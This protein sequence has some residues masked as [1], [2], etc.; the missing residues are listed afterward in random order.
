MN[1]RRRSTQYKRQFRVVRLQ[2]SQIPRFCRCGAR[3]RNDGA[4]RACVQRWLTGLVVL[5]LV[6]GFS[7]RVA[8]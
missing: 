4:C 5:F 7:V 8:S 3:V 6:M 1:K 2:P